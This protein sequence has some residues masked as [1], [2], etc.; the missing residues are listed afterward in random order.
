MSSIDATL[1]YL[2][3]ADFADGT[4]IEQPPTDRSKYHIEGADYNGT[5]YTDVVN[6]SKDE[7]PCTAFTLY[8]QQNEGNYWRVYLQDGCFE[9][10]GI[11]F[12]THDQRFE[13]T[14]HRLQ[15]I[16]NREV[17]HNTVDGVPQPPHISRY[18][19]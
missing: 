4:F 6:Y 14:Q 19:F 1:R 13:P 12:Q 8:D 2:F 11:A 17:R 15:L 16:F 5:A 3:R 7:S 18:F 9:H 10:N